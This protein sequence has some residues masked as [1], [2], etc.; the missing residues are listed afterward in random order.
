MLQLKEEVANLKMLSHERIVRYLGSFSNNETFILSVSLEYMP[1]KSLYDCL[2]TVGRFTENQ[3]KKYTRQV[4]EGVAFLH[5]LKRPIVHRQIK[6]A[7]ILKDDK[8]NVKLADFGMA[9]QLE[10]SRGANTQHEDLYCW[11]A[12][13]IVCDE[14]YGVEVDIWSVGCTV[15]E[16]LTTEPPWYLKE[17]NKT[18]LALNSKKYPVYKL[19]QLTSNEAEDFLK[20]CFIIN[21][22]DRPSAVQLLNDMPFC[23]HVTS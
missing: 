5:S 8:D 13:E 18:I 14:P 19:P 17:P 1:G 7:N 16:M 20:R 3:T 21:P 11:S 15:V 12:P 23:R 9:K 22:R 6:G 2:Q 10:W 4:L